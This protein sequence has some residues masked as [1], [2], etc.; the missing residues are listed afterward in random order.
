MKLHRAGAVLALGL[1]FLSPQAGAQTFGK[2]K[3]QY[4]QFHWEVLSSPHFDVYFYEGG[5]KVAEDVVAIA[6]RASLKLSH[7]LDHRL[8]KKI[9]IILYNSH[10]DF[11]QT[12]LT[13]ELLDE[14]VGGFTEP[15]KSRVVVPF[16]GSYEELRHVVVHELTHAFMFDILYGGTVQSLFSSGAFINVP[17][18][19]AEGLAEWESL[20]MEP[21]CE[22]FM[23]DGII[24]DYLVPL[25]YD[26][27][28]YLVYK[29]GQAAMSFIVRRYG[30]EKL[31]EL[32][33]RVRTYHSTDRAVE[34]VLGVE[35]Q[36]LSED[37][38]KDLKKQYWPQVAS[39][40]DPEKFARR[41]TDHEKDHSNL[42][43]SAAIS[44]DGDKVAYLSDR[45]VYTDLYLMSALDGRVLS[46]LVHTAQ[47]KQFENIPSFQNSVCWTPDSKQLVFVAKSEG[48]DVL[49]VYDVNSEKVVRELPFE[50]DAVA[51][52]AVSPD[53]RSLAFEGLKGGRN[54]IYLVD[55]ASG[56]LRRL[57]DDDYDE[58]DLV[59][60]PDGQL[61]FSSD[62]HAS[63]VDLSA[64]HRAGEAGTYGIFSLDPATGAVH[65]VLFTGYDDSSPAWSPDG[66][67]LAFVSLRDHGQNLYL[68][69]PADSTITQVTQLIG[70]IYSVSWA[71]RADRLVFSALNK[72]GW[73][74]FASRDPLASDSVVARLRTANPAESFRLADFAL[75]PA[76]AAPP[77]T[78]AAGGPAGP[79][80]AGA[81]A[82]APSAPAL[83]AP[84]PAAGSGAPGSAAP[85]S[86]PPRPA[87]HL[88]RSDSAST[89]RPAA[90]DSA[91][92][93]LG[94]AP[95][96]PAAPDSAA[97]RLAA[98]APGAVAVSA[99]PPGPDSLAADTLAAPRWALTRADTLKAEGAADSAFVLKAQPYHAHFSADFLSGGFAYNSLVGFGGS[100]QIAVSDFL[101]NDRF[102]LATDLFT[103]S[104]SETNF[105]ALYNYLPRRTDFA[106]G[107]FH[108]KN[109]YFS[110]V[111][112]L[113]EQFT[114][115][116]Y[117][118]ERSYGLIGN[119]SYPFSKY[120]RAELDLSLQGLS[121]GYLSVDTTG[122]FLN[123]DTSI[124]YVIAAPTISLVSDNTLDGYFGPLDGSRWMLS[125][126][127]ALPL[128]DR[129]LS[130]TTL[131]LDYRR[132][133]HL[134][135]GYSVA[136]RTLAVGSFGR[137]PQPTY[138]GGATTLRG[139]DNIDNT[140]DVSV[141]VLSG[142][143]AVL[144]T[145]EFRFPFIRHLGLGA[146]LPISFFNIE[147]VAFAD[148]GAAW[149]DGLR[150]FS[151]DGGSL[152]LV[153]PRAS[154]GFGIRAAVAYFLVHVDVAWP[155]QPTTT[156]PDKHPR[157]HFSIGPEF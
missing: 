5:R 68:F 83:A 146:P 23:R 8:S 4:K 51:Y 151:N 112:S 97:A 132:Y 109:Y 12:N 131:S 84:T 111:N 31:S 78:A 147:G 104:L 145:L 73:D 37:W 122:Y 38:A 24:H 81:P 17:L 29:E 47:S 157:W 25:Q 28:G 45:R 136:F 55:L 1:L 80:P 138:L 124:T 148:V 114:N 15:L 77:A 119:V 64:A 19:L 41:L 30:R 2:N 113:G 152:H 52:P 85:S 116:N 118:S 6:E 110:R 153:D 139:Y 74:V 27:G 66:K 142:R 59:F 53:G 88:A 67:S 107:L 117:F 50:F 69:H 105:L 129:S 140:T 126:T 26:P 71:R 70:G 16:T 60:A 43:T 35:V 9:P 20:G 154:F 3:I 58:K 98:A 134:G 96:P 93:R 128:G 91:S 75:R 125:A 141:D 63:V 123:T 135:G 48:S 34:R 102:F 101:G 33:R 57:T 103:A 54:D 94:A 86:A 121:L 89:V 137:N 32:V 155:T 90:A 82:A 44:P 7:D 95:V 56:A 22:Q 62:R 42:N 133:F 49:Y 14:G 156:N 108:F 61:T 13:D 10:N 87:L 106:V 120:K 149:N 39:L 143:K 46:R 76:A 115:P 100:T 72:G 99:P 130:F 36:K 127:Q 40:D 92:A 11:A 18:W 150:V 144:S 79:A 21:G 65:E